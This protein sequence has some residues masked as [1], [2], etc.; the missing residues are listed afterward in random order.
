[1]VAIGL[2]VAIGSLA[3][4]PDSFG[5]TLAVVQVLGIIGPLLVVRSYGY[6]LVRCPQEHQRE[7]PGEIEIG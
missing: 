5:S 3:P 6:R 1:L 2:G 7:Q 4:N